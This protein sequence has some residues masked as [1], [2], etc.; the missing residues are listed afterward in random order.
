MALFQFL[1]VPDLWER[2]G[3]VKAL[4]R[5]I[6]SYIRVGAAQVVSTGKVGALLGVFQKLIA[7]KS[8]DHEG[9]YLLQSMVEF[10][11]KEVIGT[12]MPGI[13]SLLFQ[14]LTSSKTTK[15]IK[16]F[17]VF[18]FLYSAHYGGTSVQELCDGIQANI[19]GM[20]LERLVI[21]E[22]Q[23]V[24]GTTER[25]ICAVG[26]TKWLCETPCILSGA[27]RY[28]SICSKRSRNNLLC[29]HAT[30]RNALAQSAH[31]TICSLITQPLE[32][33]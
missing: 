3:N 2:P 22:V 16:S 30:S 13:F 29:D 1:L 33:L 9:F 28:V 6:Q 23:K 21:L 10:M 15:F 4:V 11:P 31:A 19:F 17:L 24:S 14:R 27:Y 32:T 7:S 18:I 5:L 8:N 12:Y 25:K 26:M 20:V